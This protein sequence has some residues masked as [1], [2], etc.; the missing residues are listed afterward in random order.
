LNPSKNATR[1]E[2]IATILQALDVQRFWPKGEMFNDVN[3]ETPFA[4]SIETAARDGVM[5]G[6]NDALGNP[7]GEFR[8]DGAINRAE[9][10]KLVTLA[11]KVYRENTDEIRSY[12]DLE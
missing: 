4:S 8:P 11:V 10:A 1:A 12:T 9:T 2:V 5:S 3:F 6:Y 7:S